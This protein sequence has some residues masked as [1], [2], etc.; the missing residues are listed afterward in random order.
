MGYE[1]KLFTKAKEKKEENEP[2]FYL[3]STNIQTR[4]YKVYYMNIREKVMCFLLAF[5]VG[6]AVG[7][8]FYGGIGKDEFGNPTQVTRI[9]NFAISVLTGSVAGIMFL[10]VRVQQK[11]NKYKNE[12]RQQFRDMLE[13]LATSM[14]A[15]KNVIDSFLA[16]QGDLSIQYEEQA[17]ILQ[18]LKIIVSGVQNNQE[19][20]D[21]IYDFGKRSDIKDIM[22]FANVFKISYRKGGNMK[23][24]IRNTHEILKDKLEISEDIETII[25]S[26]KTEQN[27]MMCM[28]ILL[29]GMIKM[30]SPD[31]ASNFVSVTGIIST[32]IAI[33]LFVAAYYVGRAVLDIKL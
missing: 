30:M 31:F 19:I 9:L 3:S 16:V 18:E 23:E 8:L 24:I 29:I 26:N 12:L 17:F 1:M 10:P 6:A 14:G 27:V 28:P 2:Q 11:I 33:I 22:V 15:G 7:Y 25:T 5:I 4:N 13:C 20:E 21:L 32:T